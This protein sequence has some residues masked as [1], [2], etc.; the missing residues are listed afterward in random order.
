VQAEMM[1]SE[2]K[3]QDKDAA[4]ELILNCDTDASM[5]D[6]NILFLKLTVTLKKM[7]G[8]TQAAQTSPT[9]DNLNHLHL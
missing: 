1:V 5:S 8:Q 2:R 7:T 6:D 4:Q 9:L 3:L